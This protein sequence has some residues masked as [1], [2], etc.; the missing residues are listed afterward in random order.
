M[1]SRSSLSREIESNESLKK[2]D[3]RRGVMA[4]FVPIKGEGI[5]N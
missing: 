4:I 1:S 2:Q 3:A 5:L